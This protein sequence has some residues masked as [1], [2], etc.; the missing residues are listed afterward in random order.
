[1][2][3]RK[4]KIM[5]KIALFICAAMCI[6][7]VGCND[8]GTPVT[9]ETG[10]AET[11]VIT[12]GSVY[13]EPD[14]PKEPV[15]D[16]T[17]YQIDAVLDPDNMTLSLTE[18]VFFKNTSDTVWDKVYFRIYPEASLQRGVGGDWVDEYGE[19]I[20]PFAE[21]TP[22]E[23]F[24]VQDEYT[25]EIAGA[26][27]GDTGTAL[28]YSYDGDDK[29]TALVELTAPLAPGEHTSLTLEFLTDIAECGE[30]FGVTQMLY[31]YDLHTVEEIANKYYT[32]QLGNFYPILCPFENGDFVRHEYI[33]TPECFYSECADYEVTLSLP[34]DYMAVSSG[35]ESITGTVNGITSYKMTAENMRDFAIIASNEYA[36]EPLTAEVCGVAVRVFAPDSKEGFMN[37]RAL[38]LEA[39]SG[40][41]EAYTQAYGEL[42]YSEVDVCIT[43]Y[44]NGG[45][46]YPGLVVIRDSESRYITEEP[47]EFVA[48]DQFDGIK[49]KAITDTTGTT[50]HEIAHQWFYAVIGN[51]QYMYPFIDESFAA[52]SELV[53]NMHNGSTADDIAAEMYEFEFGGGQ[54]NAGNPDQFPVDASCGSDE[55][56][57]HG[58]YRNGKIFLYKLMCAMG[59][60]EFFEMMR[61]WYTGNMFEFVTTDGFLEH[62]RTYT[63]GNTEVD[64]LV[65]QYFFAEK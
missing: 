55:F 31:S 11:T 20:D 36:A 40:A 53:Y 8:S 30:R 24:F 39:A 65:K 25:C 32:F 6:S 10:S 54:A 46:E 2:S 48:A 17:L 3:I 38:C 62:M 41:V 9:R 59:E 49:Q 37:Q 52:F 12:S 27:D 7:A 35:T 63:E 60:N 18:T 44:S 64:A 42:P 47:S 22:L 43:G 5:K 61:E 34:E 57:T 19:P 26:F 1:M 58:V 15:S 56:H 14:P 29:T 13:D 16:R 50:A 51:D 23:W 4:D 21:S 28:A 33:D 45:M